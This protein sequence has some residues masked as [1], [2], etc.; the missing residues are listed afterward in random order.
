MHGGTYG[1]EDTGMFPARSTPHR[2]PLPPSSSVCSCVQAARVLAHCRTR[3]LPLPAVS[4][5][6][7][8][9]RA[10]RK[11][12]AQRA[13]ALTHSL[14]SR[15]SEPA[16]GARFNSACWGGLHVCARCSRTILTPPTHS[17][18]PF[19]FSSPQYRALA[20]RCRSTSTTGCLRRRVR[21]MCARRSLSKGLVRG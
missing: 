9:L 12:D 11:S 4:R 20:R 21:T 19:T 7:V 10:A 13:R 5:W 16:T 14:P 2:T 15:T 17:T 8:G 3:A 6:G 1:A 18:H